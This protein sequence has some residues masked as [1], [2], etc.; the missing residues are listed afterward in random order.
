MPLIIDGPADPDLGTWDQLID[1]VILHL[2]GYT[3]DQES[4]GSVAA[5]VSAVDQSITV[6]D[7]SVFSRGIVEIGDELVYVQRIDTATSRLAAVVRGYRSS[8]ATSHAVGKLVRDNPRFPR[9][10]VRRA[11]EQSLRA[12]W[13]RL[14][15]VDALELTTTQ[16]TLYALPE[17]CSGVLTVDVA[18]SNDTDAW[19]PLSHWSYVGSA[20]ST[21]SATGKA[22]KVLCGSGRQLRVVFSQRPVVPEVGEDWDTTGLPDS[23]RDVIVLGAC[24]RLMTMAEV[25][26]GS[27]VSAEAQALQQTRPAGSGVSLAKFFLGLY[28]QRVTEEQLSLQQQVRIRT[29]KGA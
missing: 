3:E 2:S 29:H 6:D 1:E 22:L 13:P 19:G 21:V 28:E 24:Y 4:I 26:R 18:A 25:G 16:E 10:A 5:P 11:L 23:C 12:T 17:Q 8:T 7:V 20:P 9:I 14:F 27:A 15:A